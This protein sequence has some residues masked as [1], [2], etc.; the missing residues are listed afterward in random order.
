[1]LRR[2]A[3]CT[4]A[5]ALLLPAHTATAEASTSAPATKPGADALAR[6]VRLGHRPVRYSG[7]RR[8]VRL[9]F[10]ADGGRLVE[11]A[12]WSSWPFNPCVRKTLRRQGG[13]VVDAWAEGYWRLPRTGTYTAVL[14]PCEDFV[15]PVRVQVRK[16]VVQDASIDGAATSVGADPDRTHLVRVPV[17]AGE[18]VL[19]DPSATPR[20]VVRADGSLDE[21]LSYGRLALDGSSGAGRSYVAARPGST[22]VV[23]RALQHPGVLDGPAVA[24]ANEGVPF[25]EHDVT[26]T[27]RAGQWVYPELLD[28]AGALVTDGRARVDVLGAAGHLAT[29][30]PGKATT[31][32]C[33]FAVSGPWQVPADGTYRMVVAVAGSTADATFSLRVRAA[34]QAPALTLDGPAVT[35]TSTTPGQWIVGPYTEHLSGTGAVVTA[36][37][38]S[39]DLTDWRMSLASG[40]PNDCGPRDTSNGCP[41]YWSVTLTPDKPRLLAPHDGNNGPSMA[42]L[43]VPPGVKG[44]LEVR[45][46]GQ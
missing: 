3:G 4:A 15:E 43:T 36:G 21:D 42:V 45:L 18:R 39:A 16:V 30:C 41:D 22:L 37:N 13:G 2:L 32:P 23:T 12:D 20:H 11:L 24:L 38:A 6:D 44:S 1:M 19:L 34:A 8:S 35:Y 27:A 10:H 5:L 25:R 9:T 26:F 29:S 14:R 7:N 31:L 17:A 28:S 46:T 40:F 33:S